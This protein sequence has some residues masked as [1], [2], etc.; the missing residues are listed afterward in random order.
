[1]NSFYAK[2]ILE[3]TRRNYNLIADDFSRTRRNL[4]P[5]LS[6]LKEYIKNGDKILDLGCG[7][8]RLVELL[9]DRD[10]EYTG[11]DNSERLIELARYKYSA[12]KIKFIVTDGFNLPFPD[13]YF[14]KIFSVAV[15]HHIPS[16]ELRLKFLSEMRRV[17]KK[18]GIA[19]F[20]VWN[21]WQ[22]KGIKFQIKY[23][24]LKILGL[25]RLDFKD[26]L[27]PYKVKNARILRYYHAFTKKELS[28][29]FLKA[30]FAVDKAG[31]LS[32]GDKGGDY[33]NYYIIAKKINLR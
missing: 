24:L 8:G 20:M 27:M 1:M 14:D 4:W 7:N 30:G 9:K 10:I 29:L 6:F 13:N 23:F 31:L 17:L 19:V 18:D 15:L 28:N 32:R 2:K 26:V 21:L 12:D 3:D 22:R 5:E 11:V 25:S 33:Y 16:R